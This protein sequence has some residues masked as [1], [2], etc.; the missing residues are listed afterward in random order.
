M[1]A[2]MGP[3]HHRFTA[4]IK[5]PWD[6]KQALG[7]LRHLSHNVT[8]STPGQTLFPLPLPHPPSLYTDRLIT[9]IK[10]FP[11]AVTMSFIY[12]GSRLSLLLIIHTES[13][14][15]QFVI[16]VSPL[17]LNSPQ[18][19]L[20]HCVNVFSDASI[21]KQWQQCGPIMLFDFVLDGRGDS[22]GLSGCI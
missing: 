16:P 10:I 14:D 8:G 15:S 11:V 7:R 6:D 4:A 12:T 2:S 17:G 20:L 13:S 22:R 21:N 9:P 3:S 5:S 18:R 1:A 19:W